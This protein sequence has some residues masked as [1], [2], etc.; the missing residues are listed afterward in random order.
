M[1]NYEREGQEAFLCALS[2]EL[3]AITSCP[4]LSLTER[5]CTHAKI[6]IFRDSNHGL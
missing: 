2:P 6:M 4:D 3:C 5:G 1:S